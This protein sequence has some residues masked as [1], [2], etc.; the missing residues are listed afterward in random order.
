MK[1][2]VSVITSPMVCI[3][4]NIYIAEWRG[5]TYVVGGLFVFIP[6]LVCGGLG[7]IWAT[8]LFIQGLPPLTENFSDLA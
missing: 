3:S 4:I 8:L 1:K 7:F 6:L 2:I 5:K